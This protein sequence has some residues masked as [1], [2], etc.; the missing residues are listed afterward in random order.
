MR[1]CCDVTQCIALLVRIIITAASNSPIVCKRCI[2]SPLTFVLLVSHYNAQNST[3]LCTTLL[4]SAL[5]S[6]HFPIPHPPLYT[7]RYSFFLIP[8]SP[9]NSAV[10][11]PSPSAPSPHNLACRFPPITVS[12]A[13][14]FPRSNHHP[15]QPSKSFRN[16]WRPPGNKSTN[17]AP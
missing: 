6:L 2:T 13:I 12:R 3:L 8:F 17:H 9:A 10:Y 15:I 7:G 5:F 16:P 11:L 4:P 14:L 1:S